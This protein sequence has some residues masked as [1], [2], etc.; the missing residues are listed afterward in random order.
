MDAGDA[1]GIVRDL[2]G[3]SAS[4]P[5]R[6]A[7]V[8]SVPAPGRAVI[9][10]SNAVATDGSQDLSAASLIGSAL[11]VG[12]VVRIDVWRG[13]VLILGAVGV[14]DYPG[15]PYA[16][17]LVT[18]IAPLAA[19][20]AGTVTISWPAGRFSVPP[21][22]IPAITGGSTRCYCMVTANSTSSVTV[23]V[24]ERDLADITANVNVAVHGIQ[25]TSTNATG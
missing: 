7:T 9:R 4:S 17:A 5:V 6:Y 21:G 24:V 13:D 15:Q 18:G 16:Q 2:R 22:C 8:I 11:R 3:P 12:A 14:D 19:A 23:T 1:L 25:M 10:P 20:S